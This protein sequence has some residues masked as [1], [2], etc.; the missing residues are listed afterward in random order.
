[1][2]VSAR[3]RELDLRHRQLDAAIQTELRHPA[4]DAARIAEMKRE[5]L[6]LKE[7]LESLRRN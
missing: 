3:I 1:M 2:A 4:A 5:K 7:Q 6:K